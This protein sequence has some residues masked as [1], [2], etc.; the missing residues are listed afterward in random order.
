MA[1]GDKTAWQ[2][3]RRFVLAE[4]LVALLV[5]GAVG[6]MTSLDPGRSAAARMVAAEAPFLSGT[7]GCQGLY[8]GGDPDGI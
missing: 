5:V 1:Q 2:W 3:L 4:A 8:C 7:M 6:W